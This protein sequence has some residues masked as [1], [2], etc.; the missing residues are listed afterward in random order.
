MPSRFWQFI[1]CNA[2][3]SAPAND[4][5]TVEERRLDIIDAAIADLPCLTREVFI[6]HRFNDLDYARIAERLEISIAEVEGHISLALRLLHRSLRPLH[7]D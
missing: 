1:R 5:A 6:L 4:V 2:T 7:D 3:I